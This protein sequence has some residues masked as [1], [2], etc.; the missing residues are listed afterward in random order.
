MSKGNILLIIDSMGIGG[1]EKVTL[2]LAQGFI[3]EGYNVDLIVCDNIIEF[4]IP[5]NIRL[6]I[7]DFKK[8]FM[9]YT[10][11]S[12][13]L[14]NMVD[15]IKNKNN[16]NFDLILVEL[17]KA[18]RLMKN[19]KHPNIYFTVQSTLSQ[20]AFKNRIGLR[21]YLKRKNLQKIYNNLNIITCSDGIRKDLINI[22]GINPKSI[23]T[24]FNPVDIDEINKLSLKNSPIN[25]NDYIVHI[26]RFAK[27]KRHD[28]LI[29]AF[30]KSNI[31]TKLV[32]VGDGEEKENI[33]TLIK[34]LKI[35]DKIILTGFQK[36]P[37]PILKNAKLFVLSS[38]YEG[39]PTVLIEALALNTLIISTNCKSGPNEI[40]TNEL[41]KYLT[42]VNNIEKLSNMMIK[43]FN[44]PYQIPDTAINNFTLTV[45]IKKYINLTL[46]RNNV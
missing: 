25:Q 30:A 29:K 43:V 33:I 5:N 46:K 2:T 38:E 37:Y 23:Q 42:E 26:G 21:L 3:N 9:D 13:K 6:H 7:L 24:I 45:I 15:D 16:K 27:V 44:K 35:E 20:S 1:A 28:I 14:H 40:M 31:N 12:R 10:R 39:L 32:L 17:Q 22:I 11:Y 36:N 41:H 8:S 19:Y 18:T 34:E 4:D